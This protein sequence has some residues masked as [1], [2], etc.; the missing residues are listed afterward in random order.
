MK[1]VTRRKALFEG[2]ASA[3]KLLTSTFAAPVEGEPLVWGGKGVS[4]KTQRELKAVP[5]ACWQCVTRDGIIGYVEDGR[6]VKIE[7]NPELPRTNGKLC[8]RGQGGIGQSYDPDRILYPMKHVGSERGDGKWKRISWDEALDELTAKL[9]DLRDR[10]VPEKFMFHYGRMKAS[11]SKIIKSYFLKAFGTGTIGNHTSICEG[12]KWVAQELVWGKHYDVNDVARTNFVLNFGCSVF[13]AHTN[14]IPL[15][16][17]MIAAKVDRGVPL[18][19][20]DV[21]QSN[22][23]AKSREWVPIKP[24]TDGAVVL[25]MAHHLLS[26]D[27][28]EK[29]FIEKWTNV[30]VKELKEHV[31]PYTP[32]WAEGISTVPAAKIKSLA[33]EYF[34][35]R[36]STI[37]SYRGAIAHYNGVDA[38]RAIMMLE[39]IAGNIERPG[40]RC[41]GIGAKWK[42][43]YPTPKTHGKKLHILDGD[44]VKF[45]NHHVSHQVLKMIKDG[46]N[47]RPEI[48]M[49]YC[50][51]PAYVNGGCEENIAVLK[52]KSLI[53]Y[54]VSVDIAYSETAQLADLIL[55]DTPYTERWDWEDMASMDMVHEYYIRQP[56]IQPLGEARDFK[57]VCCELARRLGGDVEKA[58]PFRSAKEFVMDA[59][60]HTPAI[61]AAGGFE[62]MTKHGAY[63]DKNEKPHYRTYAKKLTKKDLEG[64]I[65]DEKTGVYWKGKPGQDYTTT[66]GAYKLYVGQKFPHGVY[67]GF[68]P[69]KINKSGFFEIRSR[70]LESHGLP[71]LPTWTP[72][73]EHEVMRDGELVLI[74]YK[75]PMQSHSRTQNCKLLT[76]LFHDNPAWINPATAERLGIKDGDSVEVA[77]DFGRIVTKARVTAGIH[78]DAIAIAMHCGHWAYGRYA[79]GKKSPGG[80]DA[81]GDLKRIWWRNHGVHPNWVI[82]SQPA[83]VGGENRWMDTVVRVKPA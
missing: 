13:E 6:L 34:D 41:R 71:G 22:T 54:L 63:V 4:H 35:S 69:D 74:T 30:T 56:L 73:P 52:D 50:Y 70:L 3:A 14:H 83:P 79:S 45:A 7:G 10:G 36:P 32:E 5:S 15:S 18:V 60:E 64:T 17:R 42:N 49:T 40:G 67:V 76:E 68:K 77:S 25:A 9:K 23:A 61:K 31:K 58:L 28:V 55:P 65:L 8:A 53:P 29:D 21:R 26:Q 16:Q 59:C 1:T 57:D 33:D 46:K 38:E 43:S 51:N 37:M 19:T 20:F 47:G 27:K 72:I 39:A 75:V 2:L 81:D 82:P 44:G 80:H 11:S 66:K 62:Y 48:Y 12:G 78:P 24:G